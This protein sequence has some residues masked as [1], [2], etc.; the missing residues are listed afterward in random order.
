[1]IPK[2]ELPALHITDINQL[3]LVLAESYQHN[4]FLQQQLDEMRNKRF[5]HFNDEENWLWDAGGNNYLD[6]LVCPVLISADDMRDI[7]DAAKL[8]VTATENMRKAWDAARFNSLYEKVLIAETN[9]M[10][11][12]NDDQGGEA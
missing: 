2:N 9:L 12:F 1:M 10:R 7:R 8:L 5:W 6:S 4:K 3:R 11:C